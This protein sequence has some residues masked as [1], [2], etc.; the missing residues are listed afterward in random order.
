MN[1]EQLREYVKQLPQE[2]VLRELLISQVDCNT[3]LE[4]VRAIAAEYQASKKAAAK[5]ILF[6]S[7]MMV[8]GLAINLIVA[9]NN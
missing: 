6:I 3:K 5:A 1:R 7:V 9:I 2:E 4:E 8:I